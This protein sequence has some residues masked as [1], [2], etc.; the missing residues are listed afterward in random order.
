M[1]QLNFLDYAIKDSLT[2]LVTFILYNVITIIV[3]G[4]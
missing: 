1:L 2:Y 3:A 4:R